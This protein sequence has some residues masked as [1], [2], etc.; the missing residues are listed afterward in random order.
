[1]PLIRVIEQCTHFIQNYHWKFLF[2]RRNEWII[3]DEIKT[4]KINLMKL[5][6]IIF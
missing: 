2:E 5:K 1:M 4:L 3:W 6:K